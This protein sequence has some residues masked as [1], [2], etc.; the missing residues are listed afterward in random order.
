VSSAQTSYGTRFAYGLGGIATAVKDAAVVHFLL[1]FYTQVVGLPGP[2][3]G[4]AAAIAQIADALID[5]AIGSWSDNTRSRLGRRHPFMLGA[6]VPYAAA[7][8]LL[9]NPPAGLTGGALFAWA[10]VMMV[11]TRALLALFAIPHAALGAELSTDYAQRTQIA[12]DRTVLAWI[13]GILLPT[14]AYWLI[15]T[16]VPGAD[17]AVLD[18]RLGL[19]NYPAYAFLSAGVIL[20]VAFASALGTRSAIA[21]LPLPHERRKLTLLDPFRDVLFALRNHNF[22]RVFAAL[23]IAGG[24]TGVSTM[25]TALTWLYFWEFTTEQTS[26]LVLSSIAPTLVAWVSMGPLSRRFEKRALYFATMLVLIASSAWFPGARL[27]GLLPANG[28]DAIFWLALA[29]NFVTVYVLVV[30]GSVWPSIIADIADEYE[31]QHGE[32]KDGV[33]FAA[34]AFGLKIPQGLGNLLGGLAIAWVGVAKGM[35][36]GSVP[37]DVLLRLGLVAGPFVAASLVLPVIAMAGYDI[38]RAR[39]GELRRTLD[40]RAKN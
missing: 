3:F 29:T 11:A 18:G 16:P 32:R 28:S 7:F 5:P 9:F 8:W 39:H 12:A 24:I 10:A 34:L 27:L 31:V 33:F 6:A 4:L 22:R 38:S 21:G 25:F 1:M 35:S 36:P 26:V 13:G 15:F 23:F 17:G 20:V 14:F 37:A 30:N 19:D 2:W 40:A